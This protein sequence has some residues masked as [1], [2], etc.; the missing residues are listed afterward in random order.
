MP[1]VKTSLPKGRTPE[2]IK[3]LVQAIHA[4]LVQAL[5]IPQKDF[6]QTVTEHKPGELIY[7]ADY[8]GIER[9][10]NFMVIEIILRRGRS[11]AMK[12]TLFEKITSELHRTLNI[13]TA[14]V[15]IVLTENDFSDWSIGNGQ[16]S[17][18]LSLKSFATPKNEN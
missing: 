1:L 5:G 6:F 11:D 9:S 8:L 2:E 3:I 10:D 17:F 13:S 7:D 15:M 16:S 14:D 4:G 12:S 18:A